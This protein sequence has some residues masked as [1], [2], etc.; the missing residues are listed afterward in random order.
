MMENTGMNAPFPA[1]TGVGYKLSNRR[2]RWALWPVQL[3]FIVHVA[4]CALCVFAIVAAP[5][6]DWGFEGGWIVLMIWFFAIGGLVFTIALTLAWSILFFKNN[7]AFR[8]GFTLHNALQGI[9]CLVLGILWTA[10]SR[11]F[12]PWVTLPLFAGFI[13]CVANTVY[14]W[15]S[16]A[17]QSFGIY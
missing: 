12:E 11:F 4:F 8:V 16:K 2:A 14:I 10:T 6:R 3:A 13:W 5:Q 7:R 17:A 15:K 9:L 1:M